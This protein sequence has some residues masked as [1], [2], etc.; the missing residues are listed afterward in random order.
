LYS[1]NIGR[2][3]VCELG[4]DGPVL[5]P[6]IVLQRPYHL[7]YPLVFAH[8]GEWFMMPEMA[9]HTVQE[10]YRATEF[11]FSWSLDRTVSF[12]QLVVDPT[13]VEHKGRWWLFTGTQP[14]PES[15]IN[16]LSIFFGDSPLGPWQP[17]PRNPVLSDARSA[18]PAGQIFRVGDD[19]IRPA[20]DGTPAYGSAICFKRIVELSETEYQ[21]ELIGRLDPRWRAGL[22]GTHTVNAA[23]AVTVLDPVR[24]RNRKPVRHL[25]AN[26]R[27][28]LPKAS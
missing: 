25:A 21:E 15:A 4:S 8:R 6:R 10:V 11:P 2:I 9:G 20:Q 7:S 27:S 1:E 17:H 16:E 3:V 24:L 14:S 28:L 13:L 22:L 26:D 19:L 18:R 23:G 5:P 12:G